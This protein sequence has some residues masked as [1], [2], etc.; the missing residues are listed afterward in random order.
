MCGWKRCEF[1]GGTCELTCSVLYGFLMDPVKVMIEK[2]RKKENNSRTAI[3][4][5]F[6]QVHSKPASG[7]YES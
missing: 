3:S 1:L 5:V 2:K 4:Q 6:T 7:P